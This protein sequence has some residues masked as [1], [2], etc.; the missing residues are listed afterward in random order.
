MNIYVGNLSYEV[1]EEEL[2]KAFEVFG[3]VESAKVIKDMY[4]GR[5]RGFGFVE[6]ADEAEAQSAIDGLDGKD[7]KGRTLKV[8]MARSRSGGHRGGRNRGGGRQDGGQRFY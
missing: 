6:M 4:T 3:H 5:P 8:N 7:L 1:T 2:Q